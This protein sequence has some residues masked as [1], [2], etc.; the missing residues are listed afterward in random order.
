MQ[1]GG[2]LILAFVL[3]YWLEYLYKEILLSSTVL[4]NS[5]IHSENTR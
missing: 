1:N 3:H 5:I 4:L 2:I